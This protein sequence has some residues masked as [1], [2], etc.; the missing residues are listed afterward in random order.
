MIS[1]HRI[2]RFLL[3]FTFG[4]AFVVTFLLPSSVAVHWNSAGTATSY[5]S[6]YLAALLSL[7]VGALCAFVW[8]YLEERYR[9]HITVSK[10]LRVVLMVLGTLF[11]SLG[12]WMNL[13]FLVFN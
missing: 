1:T 4:T 6:K 3:G 5:M 2:R 8:K 9:A 7:G 11:T 10:P 13:A 12:I